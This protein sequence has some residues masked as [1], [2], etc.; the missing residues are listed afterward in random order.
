MILLTLITLPR[1]RGRTEAYMAPELFHYG[2]MRPTTAVDMY[3]FGVLAWSA[4][5][6]LS[7]LTPVLDSLHTQQHQGRL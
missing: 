6:A 4:L 2:M 3:S 1:H 7:A 5:V